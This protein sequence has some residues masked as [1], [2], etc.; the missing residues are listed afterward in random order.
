MCVRVD[1]WTLPGN[2]PLFESQYHQ[3]DIEN[4]PKWMTLC[5]YLLVKLS[6]E[7]SEQSRSSVI[8][9]LSLLKIQHEQDESARTKYRRFGASGRFKYDYGPNLGD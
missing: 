7:K 8:I 3:S 6:S 5:I 1:I 4:G 9:N 2:F